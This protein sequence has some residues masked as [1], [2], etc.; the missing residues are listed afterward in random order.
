VHV[1]PS[2]QDRRLAAAGVE[3]NARLTGSAAALLLILL[4]AEGATLLGVNR[5]LVP[6]VVIGFALIPVAALKIGSTMYRFARYY[7]GSHSYRLKG[8]PPTI[9]RL[10]GPVVIITTVTLLGSGVALL[11]VSRLWLPRMLTLHKASFVLWFAAMT[12]HV[13]A[14]VAETARLASRDWG[15]RSAAKVPGGQARRWAM[16][17]TIVLG[18][19]LG[20]WSLG[21][22]G[23]WRR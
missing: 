8:P 4:A 2:S 6:H 20:A 10:L 3:A 15:R 16:A 14:H 19:L 5:L 22:L 13:V 12:V 1:E 11:F 9:L 7:G 18:A 17:A 23:N 21:Q